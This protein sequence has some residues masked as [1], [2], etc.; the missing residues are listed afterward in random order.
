MATDLS[1]VNLLV[2]RKIEAKISGPL[3]KAFIKKFDREQTLIVVQEATQVWAK[4]AGTQRAR[5]LGGN[6]L[7]G[8]SK[9]LSV[10]TQEVA[11]QIEI[12][13]LK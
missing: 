6:S 2:R 3:I 5:H 13:M 9:G 1:K 7:R 12:F 10:L 8:F 11:L 4:E